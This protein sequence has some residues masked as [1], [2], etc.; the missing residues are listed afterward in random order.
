MHGLML[1]EQPDVETWPQIAI[2]LAAAPVSALVGWVVTKLV[3]E[4]ITRYGRSFRWSAPGCAD[5]PQ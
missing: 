3:E 2:T 4:P 5:R 1:G